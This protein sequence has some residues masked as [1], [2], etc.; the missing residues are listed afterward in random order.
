MNH[1]YVNY[2]RILLAANVVQTLENFED[3]TKILSDSSH[4]SQLAQNL[5]NIKETRA[6]EIADNGEVQEENEHTR[7]IESFKLDGHLVAKV[8][9]SD[10]EF[11]QQQ[12]YTKCGP[13]R[14]VEKKI[15]RL[16][17][18]APRLELEW[19]VAAQLLLELG[20]QIGG[21]TLD[22]F[23]RARDLAQRRLWQDTTLAARVESEIAT[24]YYDNDKVFMEMLS[25]VTE[26]FG[27]NKHNPYFQATRDEA[28][29]NTDCFDTSTPT[30]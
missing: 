24:G 18:K 21:Q 16:V 7:K 9:F 15:N 30:S 3:E 1:W 2:G 23:S 28:E 12:S 27:Q 25:I 8:S 6:R 5:T 29:S 11:E 14:E 10:C 26:G 19:R 17:G 13:A 20:G 22:Y 4:I